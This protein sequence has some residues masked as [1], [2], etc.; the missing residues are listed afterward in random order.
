MSAATLVQRPVRN[1][2]RPAPRRPAARPARPVRRRRN[3][4]LRR[5]IAAV[6]TVAVVVLAISAV[7]A[8]RSDA[9]G[10]S[11]VF[12]ATVVVAPGQTVWDIANDYVPEGEHPQAYVA[13]VLRYNAID[14]TAI[15][16]GAV[17]RLPRP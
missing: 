12:E 1:G 7:W 8:M 13:E 9:A 4:M 11:G 15:A 16:P 17:L 3:V 10:E 14:A 2:A 6:L 5:R